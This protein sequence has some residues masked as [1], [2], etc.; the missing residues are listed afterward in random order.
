MNESIY[1]IFKQLDET[2]FSPIR[3]ISADRKRILQA[4]LNQYYNII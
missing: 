4:T 3:P 2:Y 1:C